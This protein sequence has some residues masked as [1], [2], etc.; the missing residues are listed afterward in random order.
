MC[1]SFISG[2][3][4]ARNLSDWREREVQGYNYVL[5][6]VGVG[7]EESIMNFVCGKKGL[8]RELQELILL[9]VGK[10]KMCEGGV[11]GLTI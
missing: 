8:G 11:S 5:M 7:I 1:S 10:C 2:S 3:I 4:C 9:V 6:C